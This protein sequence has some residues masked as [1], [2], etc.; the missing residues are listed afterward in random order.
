[1]PSP[2]HGGFEGMGEHREDDVLYN[3]DPMRLQTSDVGGGEM[4]GNDAV[5]VP[6]EGELHS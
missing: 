1:M 6:C 3:S 5:Q 4:R 2:D